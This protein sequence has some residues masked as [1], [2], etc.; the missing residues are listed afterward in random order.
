MTAT[1]LAT[2]EVCTGPDRNLDPAPAAAPHVVQ[3]RERLSRDVRP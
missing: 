2:A 1:P 3:V